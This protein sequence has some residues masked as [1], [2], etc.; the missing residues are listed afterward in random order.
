MTFTQL[1]STAEEF[2]D[3]IHCR[4]KGVYIQQ[5]LQDYRYIAIAARLQ[6]YMVRATGI[7]GAAR[8]TQVRQKKRSCSTKA[9]RWWEGKEPRSWSFSLLSSLSPG[10]F[11]YLATSLQIHHPQLIKRVGQLRLALHQVVKYLIGDLLQGPTL[12]PRPA[13]PGWEVEDRGSAVARG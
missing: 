10:V 2:P 9:N 1:R 6:E 13:G 3:Y 12:A 5:S 11:F 7:S 8:I 4:S